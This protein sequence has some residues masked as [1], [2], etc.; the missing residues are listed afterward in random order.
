MIRSLRR[1]FLIIALASLAGTLA[2]LCLVINL[3]YHMITTSRADEVIGTPPS[4]RRKIP[5]AGGGGGPQ[6]LSRLS[7][8]H[9]DPF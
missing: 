9:G 2:A 3:G 5:R 8:H 7:G 6:G 1:R 4:V